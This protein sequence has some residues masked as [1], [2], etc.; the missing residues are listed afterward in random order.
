MGLTSIL[1]LLVGCSSPKSTFY[2]FNAAPIPQ[3]APTA[4]NTQIMVGPISLPALFDRPQI[5][6]QNTDHTVQVYE[7]Q[8]WAN[9]L[10]GDIADVIG[11]NIAGT[12]KIS[13]VWSFSQSMRTDFNYQVFIEVQ[14]IE[15][16]SGGG[17]LVDVLWSIKPSEHAKSL[18]K[19]STAANSGDTAKVIRGRSL[20]NEPV[21]GDGLN[22]LVAAQSRAF[23]RVGQE[24]ARSIP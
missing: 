22:A 10:K 15:N 12:L 17:V 7:Y 14:T 5:V 21:T 16:K 11:S 1:V 18:N 4:K 2:S 19:P 20:V 24:I 23:A 13:N 9:T 6:I 3:V 8:R